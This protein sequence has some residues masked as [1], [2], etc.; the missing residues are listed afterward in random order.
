MA[1]APSASSARRVQEGL[2][3]ADVPLKYHAPGARAGNG[4]L[5]NREGK[6][7]LIAHIPRDAGKMGIEHQ[8]AKRLLSHHRYRKAMPTAA[9]Q[10]HIGIE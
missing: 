7:F 1:A 4:F 3:Q 9:K 8:N 6:A 2:E 5:H 10:I